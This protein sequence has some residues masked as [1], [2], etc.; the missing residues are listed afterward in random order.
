MS[1]A[2]LQVAHHVRA[3]QSEVTG[4]CDQVG[5][6]AFVLQIQAER[7]VVWTSAAA[8]VRSESE[9]EIPDQ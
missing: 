1:T 4:S 8:V 9:R 6:A 2:Q 3:S 7:R 5:Q